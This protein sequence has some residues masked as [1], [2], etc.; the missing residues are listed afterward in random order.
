MNLRASFPLSA[1]LLAILLLAAPARAEEEGEG[2]AAL[3]QPSGAS[4]APTSATE[5]L[6]DCVARLP[7]QP[8]SLSGWVRNRRPRGIVDREFNFQATLRWGQAVPTAQYTFTDEAGQTLA[9]AIFRH[10]GGATE[11]VLQD[12]PALEPAAPPAWNAS[13]LGTDIT[14]L[15]LSMDFLRWPRAELNGETKFRGRLCD[16]VEVYPPEPIPGCAK[17]RLLVDREVR[18]FLQAQQVDEARKVARQ[19]WV[20]SVKKMGDRWMVQDLEVEARSSGHRTR[21]HVLS[22]E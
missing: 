13:V 2:F 12:G 21:L 8:V 14:W 5:L 16:I 10:V 19:M 9:R 20:R 7:E 4:A 15:D 6:A 17:V 22:C 18:M 1:I 3:P 11:L